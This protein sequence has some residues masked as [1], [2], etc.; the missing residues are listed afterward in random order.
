MTWNK[1]K[2]PFAY[3]DRQTKL[4]WS[5]LSR[6]SSKDLGFER[7][8]RKCFRLRNHYLDNHRLNSFL[9][10]L[11]VLFIEWPNIWHDWVNIL[12]A[13]DS[14]PGTKDYPLNNIAFGLMSAWFLWFTALDYRFIAEKS[15]SSVDTDKKCNKT[16]KIPV[17][18]IL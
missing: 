3:S 13:S 11:V 5:P 2:R 15:V 4:R 17:V 18:I 6:I 7:S 1:A 10:H 8:V 9:S 16:K 14:K 12:Y